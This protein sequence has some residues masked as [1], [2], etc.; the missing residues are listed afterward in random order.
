MCLN[1]TK[2]IYDE[3]TTQFLIV[4]SWKLSLYDQGQNRMTNVTPFEHSTGSPSRTIGKEK[5]L[6]HSNRKG[7]YNIVSICW[8]SGSTISTAYR[9]EKTLKMVSYVNLWDIQSESK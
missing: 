4:K 9:L 7:K 1:I 2:T 5:E 8:W 6:N 3:S